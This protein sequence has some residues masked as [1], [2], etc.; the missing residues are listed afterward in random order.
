M[1]NYTLQKHAESENWAPPQSDDV[2]YCSS[3]ADL[4]WHLEDWA[5][6]VGL[7]DVP[8]VA[9]IMVWKGTLEDVTDQYPDFIM[10]IGPRGGVIKE[11]C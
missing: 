7:F 5:E 9:S 3:V 10:R 4:R 11:T 8:S 2:T 6:I 1:A